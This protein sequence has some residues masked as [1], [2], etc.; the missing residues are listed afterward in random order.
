MVRTI[1]PYICA[2]NFA[3]GA[4]FGAAVVAVTSGRRP[5]RL[6]RAPRRP[7]LR[8]TPGVNMKKRQ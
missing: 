1:A 4:L 6:K 5:Q 8:W 2:A 7:S 3:I